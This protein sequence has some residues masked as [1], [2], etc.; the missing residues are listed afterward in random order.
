MRSQSGDMDPKAGFPAKESLASAARGFTSLRRDVNPWQ[1][2][3]AVALSQ[4]P[5]RRAGAKSARSYVEGRC[6]SSWTDPA[7]QLRNRTRTGAKGNAEKRGT[8]GA[9]VIT[10]IPLRKNPASADNAL[11]IERLAGTNKN[12]VRLGSPAR[13]RTIS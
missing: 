1:T 11:R 3:E 12:K 6:T 8:L 5:G 10:Q 4:G 9:K 13:M 2:F 7:V